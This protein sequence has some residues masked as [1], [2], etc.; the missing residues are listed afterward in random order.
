MSSGTV[1]KH[2]YVT[3]LDDLTGEMTL[4]CQVTWHPNSSSNLTPCDGYPS[5]N[6]ASTFP[7][8]LPT[9]LTASSLSG[10]PD[11]LRGVQKWLGRSAEESRVLAPEPSVG[12][13]TRVKAISY[14]LESTLKTLLRLRT[15]LSCGST[16]ARMMLNG[17]KEI[18]LNDAADT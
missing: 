1:A 5:L 18:L 6:S 10:L 17:L 8:S 2:D 12:H 15:Q 7:T 4:N 14:G 3:G 9:S 16:S 11:S 13:R